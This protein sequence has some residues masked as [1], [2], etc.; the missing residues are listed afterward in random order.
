MSSFGHPAPLI[1]FASGRIE[2]LEGDRRPLLGIAHPKRATCAQTILE[3]DSLLVLY[4]DGVTEATRDVVE[5]E[6]RLRVI[7]ESAQ[8]GNASDPAHVI[9][10]TMIPHGSF[11]DTA[12][13]CVRYR[14]PLALTAQNA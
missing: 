4:T 10:R 5:G 13:L 11:D 1:R 8:V 3:R 12:I 7:V 2:E 14:G 9:H 6:R